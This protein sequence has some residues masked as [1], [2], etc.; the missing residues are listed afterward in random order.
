ME[1]KV[2]LAHIS[3]ASFMGHRQ[4]EK[5]RPTRRP[6]WGYSV[7]YFDFHRKFKRKK[8][9]KKTPDAPKNESGLIQ[10]ITMGKTIR[11]KWVTCKCTQNSLHAFSIHVGFQGL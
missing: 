2:T 5:H 10:M 6:I 9:N 3:L 4:T 11:H 8:T 7:Y 1:T